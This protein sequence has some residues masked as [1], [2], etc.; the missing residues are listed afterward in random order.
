MDGI[1]QNPGFLVLR[2]HGSQIIERS[3]DLKVWTPIATNI[4]SVQITDGLA[5]SN[6]FF[7]AFTANR[8]FALSCTTGYGSGVKVTLSNMLVFSAEVLWEVTARPMR[9]RGG[10]PV[11]LLCGRSKF[12]IVVQ[13]EPSR[14]E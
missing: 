12:P 7:R 11:G 6:A 13:L 1:G 5:G 2:V 9:K 14:D 10:N 8:Q 4:G 3:L